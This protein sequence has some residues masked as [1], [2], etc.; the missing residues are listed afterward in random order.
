[1]AVFTE[2]VRFGPASLQVSPASNVHDRKAGVGAQTPEASLQ[3]A[4]WQY[5][6][7]PQSV[8]DEQAPPPSGSAQA[9]C[10][11]T[12]MPWALTMHAYG[13]VW[14]SQPQTRPPLSSGEQ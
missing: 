3:V 6:P 2:H 4:F 13:Q 7:V 11:A 8:F 5:S 12:L 1:M 14:P 10:E 9:P